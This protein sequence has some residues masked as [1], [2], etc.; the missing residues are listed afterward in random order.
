MQARRNLWLAIAI[1]MFLAGSAYPGFAF[2]QGQEALGLSPDSETII[3][4]KK[5]IHFAKP[6]LLESDFLNSSPF[7]SFIEASG[8][9]PLD[10]QSRSPK[11]GIQTDFSLRGSGFQGVLVLVN[12]QRLNDPQTGHYN[13]DLALTRED[14]QRIEVIPGLPSSLFGPDAIGGAINIVVKKPDEKRRVLELA[15][16]S[17]QAKSGSFSFTDRID[18]LGFRISLN[19]QECEGFYY[20]TDFKDFT[21]SV[22]SSLDIPDGAFDLLLGFREKEF[23]AYDFYTPGAG[24]ASGEWTKTYLLSAGLNLERAGL[25]IRPNLLWRR[26]YDKFMLDKTQVRSSYLNHHTSDVNTANIYFQKQSRILGQL[27]CG[28]EYG[29]EAIKST[30]LGSHIREHKSAFIDNSYDFGFRL[31][32][33]LSFRIDDYG[34]FGQAYTGSLGTRYRLMPGLWLHSGISRSIRLPDFTE[35]YY[36]DPTTAGQAGLCQENSTNLEAGGDYQGEGFSAGVTL[37]LRQEDDFIDWIKRSPAQSRW[38]AENITQAEVLGVEG[39]LGLKGTGC[40]SLDSNYTYIDKQIEDGGYIYKYGPNYTRHM[41]NAALGLDLPFGKQVI[42]LTYKKK[43]VRRGWWIASAYFGYNL[44]SVCS[45]GQAQGQDQK[46]KEAQ[47]F[48]RITNL[49][50]EEYQEIEGIAQPGRWI[51]AGFRLEW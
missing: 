27:G 4:S 38:R 8:F 29:Q 13:C 43:P 26:H 31:S 36:D 23:G 20:G 28:L 37:F 40:F 34:G 41:F 10:L 33:G 44:G 6:Y 32:S 47:I 9:S 2:G 50:N 12:G 49:F 46:H 5:Q 7:A 11:A 22:A 19:R 42:G 30:N 18:N 25:I 48:L 16:G 35:L 45:R 14:I 1:I 17:H 24:Y 3:M 21:A 39:Y 51:E 15:Y